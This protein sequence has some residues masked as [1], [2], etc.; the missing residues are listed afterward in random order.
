MASSPRDYNTYLLPPEPSCTIREIVEALIR[1]DVKGAIEILNS[2]E[3]KNHIDD[4]IREN[5][6]GWTLLHNAGF[7]GHL[8]L[9]KQLIVH[10][11]TVNKQDRTGKILTVITS[12]LHL[13][14]IVVLLNLFAF[15]F[16]S[17]NIFI[18]IMTY[19]DAATTLSVISRLLSN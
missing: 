10:G 19:Q 6:P 13:T 3:C 12:C 18:H 1:G 16:T 5:K 17:L 2:G 7:N 14:A 11:A 4:T 15:Y 9:C 8:Q